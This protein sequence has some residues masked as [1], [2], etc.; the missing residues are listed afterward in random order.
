MSVENG[1]R[2]G[3]MIVIYGLGDGINLVETGNV[4]THEYMTAKLLR[5]WM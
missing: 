4:A 5:G 2:R 1:V 3:Q